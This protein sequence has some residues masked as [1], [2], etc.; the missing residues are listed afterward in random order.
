[1]TSN[2]QTS[3]FT[4][5]KLTSSQEDS[6]VSLSPQLAKEKAQKMIAI[7]GR[8]CL[9]QFERFSQDGSWERMFMALLIGMRDWYSTRCVLTWKMKATK[10]NR[11]YFQLWDGTQ[12]T[13]GEGFGLLLTP[14]SVQTDKQPEK[15]RKRAEKNEYQNGT[16]YG[17]LLSQV[18]YSGIIPTPTSEIGRKS[19]FKQG[20]KSI[21]RALEEQKILPSPVASD[22]T[23]GAIIGK[24][25]TFK[26][27]SNG[28]LRKVNQNGTDG[29][30]G[31]ARTVKLLKTICA[32]DNRDRGG[33]SDPA[34][35]RRKEKGK[36]IELSMTWDGLLNP[37]F[38][39][40]MM[41]FPLNWTNLSCPN[42]SID[43][44]ESKG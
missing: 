14:T 40:Q 6:P 27:T 39:E 34:I 22:A 2:P 32:S 3:L 33:P 23:T 5:G 26:E 16:K 38:V 11:L 35:Q 15:M 9:E 7:S 21:W 44:N 10:S 24:N 19:D 31:L 28:T 42:Q 30:L 4:E 8:K 18:K 12:F 41:G 25:D 43:R 29:S 13:E 20:G 17:S 1:M 36:S 37:L